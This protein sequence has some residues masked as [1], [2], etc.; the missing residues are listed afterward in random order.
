MNKK[1]I[2]NDYIYDH[3]GEEAKQLHK[4]VESMDS[5]KI[6]MQAKAAQY[7]KA[8]QVC[9]TQLQLSRKF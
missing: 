2:S 6:S 7:N 3:F 9:L 5:F 1:I 8:V 4:L